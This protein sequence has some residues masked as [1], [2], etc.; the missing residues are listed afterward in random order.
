MVYVLLSGVILI[1][2]NTVIS[3]LMLIKRNN[4]VIRKENNLVKY[5]FLNFKKMKL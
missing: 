2:P 5:L 1:L 3:R 4:K